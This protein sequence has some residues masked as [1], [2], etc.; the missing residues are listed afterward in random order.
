MHFKNIQIHIKTYK[1]FNE[2]LWKISSACQNF[3]PKKL[4]KS[5]ISVVGIEFGL[6][7]VFRSVRHVHEIMKS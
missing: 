6:E 7:V 2:N 3:N 5:N 1:E 4:N